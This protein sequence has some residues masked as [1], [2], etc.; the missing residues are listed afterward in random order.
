MKRHLLRF[1]LQRF[2][3]NPR[4][5]NAGFTLIELL[6]VTVVGSLIMLALLALINELLLVDRNES[7]RL[8]TNREMQIALDYM[9][10]EVREASYIYT[11]HCLMAQND[12]DANLRCNDVGVRAIG[13]PTGGI[14]PAAIAG[15][16]D[17]PVL[18]FWKQHPLPD[19]LKQQCSANPNLQIDGISVPCTVGSSY[20][21]V[22]YAL[23]ADDPADNTW[24]GGAQ[25]KRYM[26]TEFTADG[27]ARTPGYAN[28]T[29]NNNSFV[30]WPYAAVAGPVGGA[31]A[32]APV[33]VDF[34]DGRALNTSTCP[35]GYSISPH[36]SAL[37]AAGNVDNNLRS[38]YAC[39]SPFQTG[40]HQEAI[41]YLQGNIAG[42]IGGGLA[43]DDGALTALQTRVMARGVFEAD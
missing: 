6:I 19:P 43:P 7:V 37:A 9:A 29:L 2:R 40:Q 22:V 10:N 3:T 18:A 5:R 31:N 38:F 35:R 39:I 17:V 25:I 34:V 20:A 12:A 26:L 14:L 28:P 23:S 4:Y 27:T 30:D 42:R 16:R 36:P 13:N 21:L 33:L 1:W 24:R 41:I 8:E 32:N 15:N 11:G